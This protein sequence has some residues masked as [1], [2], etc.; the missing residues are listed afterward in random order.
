MGGTAIMQCHEFEERLNQTLD[1]RLAPQGDAA[2]VKHAE[3]CASC[4][5]NLAIQSEM[6]AMLTQTSYKLKHNFTLQRQAFSEEIVAQ[7]RHSS[8]LR[9]ASR[10]RLLWVLSVACSTLL[11]VSSL[12]YTARKHRTGKLAKDVET[13]TVDKVVIPTLPKKSE[14][15]IAPPE[16]QYVTR[17]QP[18]NVDYRAALTTFAVQIGESPELEEVHETMQP[19]LRPIQSSFRV[20]IDALRRTMPHARENRVAPPK[21]GVLHIRQSHWVV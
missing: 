12:V 15:I 7:H 10:K 14:K 6:Y 19:G 11:V 21:D 17:P 8:Q 2:L 18:A 13:Q 20:A 5:Q 4:A 3:Q 9:N 16:R 1:K